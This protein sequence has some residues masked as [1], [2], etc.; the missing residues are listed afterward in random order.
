MATFPLAKIIK[1]MNLSTSDN[2][3][4][5]LLALRNAQR[6]VTLHNKSWEDLLKQSEQNQLRSPSPP[7]RSNPSTPMDKPPRPR[8]K[9]KQSTYDLQAY[10]FE[11]ISR[12]SMDTE[13]HSFVKSLHS[14]WCRRGELTPK[15]QEVL[16][17]I[18]KSKGYRF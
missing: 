17:K 16:E 6:I 5:A 1:L 18:C 7:Q 12:K 14:F 3:H 10:L 4:K 13:Q 15:Q 9:N 2:D 8:S 11:F